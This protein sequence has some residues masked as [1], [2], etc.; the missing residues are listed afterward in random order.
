[1]AKISGL[2]HL[3]IKKFDW[4]NHLELLPYRLET[5]VL[6]AHMSTVK[7]SVEI[8]C[9][10]IYLCRST[11]TDLYILLN[12]EEDNDAGEDGQ[13]WP[14]MLEWKNFEGIAPALTTLHMSNM[15]VLSNADTNLLALL[16]TV[17][18]QY[19]LVEYSCAPIA[20]A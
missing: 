11:V 5:L 12:G 16:W 9:Q 2:K 17:E 6:E 4:V 18:L 13:I 7:N 10:A 14:F 8:L 15:N 1:M 3:C 19:L 20:G